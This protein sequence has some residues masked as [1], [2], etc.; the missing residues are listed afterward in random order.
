MLSLKNKVYLGINPISLVPGV[1]YVMLKPST[2]KKS[3]SVKSKKW[4]IFLIGF[5]FCLPAILF[6]TLFKYIPIINSFWLSFYNY[7]PISQ[8][9]SGLDNYERLLGDTVFWQSLINTS[10][11][12]VSVTTLGTLIGYIFA[13]MFRSGVKGSKFFRTIYFLPVL[14]SV[15]VIS[16]VWKILYNPAS[17]GFS[18]NGFLKLLS[19]PPQGFLSDPH[20]ALGAL[21]LPLIWQIAGYNMVIF[22]AA[23]D[24]IDGEILEAA[25][26]EGANFW[27][28][29]R[30]IIIPSTRYAISIVV[31]L[32]IMRT[33]RV[34]VPVYVMTFGD[35]N[36]ATE[37]IATWLYKQAFRFWEMGY[38][39]AIAVVLFLIIMVLTIIQL[40][41]MREKEA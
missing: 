37:T 21:T 7:N 31:I 35:P 18:F 3:K 28:Q 19:I 24:G 15:T 33:F 32:A 10:I 38:G 27:Q 39:S 26:V 30:Y 12:V 34:F 9:F 16:L 5:T 17:L 29:L 8:S 11:I 6:F 40:V 25:Q 4:R 22:I 1:Y 20:Q 41:L 23:L 2:V 14:T 36:H 13:L